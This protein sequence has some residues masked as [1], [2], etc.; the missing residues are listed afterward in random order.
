[1]SIPEGSASWD[2]RYDTVFVVKPLKAITKTGQLVPSAY[3]HVKQVQE[4]T[5]TVAGARYYLGRYKRVNMFKVDF[6]FFQSL[7]AR[8]I[9]LSKI[10]S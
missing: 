1:L 5:T 2:A 10:E 8:V 6:Q 3:N 4:V 9:I 7:S